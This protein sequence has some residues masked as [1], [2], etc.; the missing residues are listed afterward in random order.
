MDHDELESEQPGLRYSPQQPRVP[1]LCQLDLRPHVD[2][3][4]DEILLAAGEGCDRFFCRYAAR[5]R[6][7]LGEL[8]SCSPG[9]GLFRLEI[10]LWRVCAEGCRGL[11]PTSPRSCGEPC[12]AV[13]CGRSLCD[14]ESNGRPRVDGRQAGRGYA[15]VATGAA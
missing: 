4:R 2:P 10:P 1:V 15:R 14:V 12:R 6:N 13:F 5:R 9:P 8:L 11:L 3:E 7:D